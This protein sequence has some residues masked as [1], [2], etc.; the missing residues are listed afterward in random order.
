MIVPLKAVMP[1]TISLKVKSGQ[2]FARAGVNCFWGGPLWLYSRTGAFVHFF[3]RLA[4]L[5]KLGPF[6]AG[7]SPQIEKTR[8]KAYTAVLRKNGH[9][10]SAVEGSV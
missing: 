1:Q 10:C 6:Q 7:L 3:L 5:K 8:E 2:L 4:P 9:T